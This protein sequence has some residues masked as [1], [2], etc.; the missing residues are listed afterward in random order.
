MTILKMSVYFFPRESE[1]PWGAEI[2]KKKKKKLDK[3]AAEAHTIINTATYGIAGD[4]CTLC[5]RVGVS[6]GR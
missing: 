3:Q 6:R 2:R 5:V 4:M 1:G